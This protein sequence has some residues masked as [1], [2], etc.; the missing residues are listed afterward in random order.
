MANTSKRVFLK[1]SAAG[2]ALGLMPKTLQ[3]ET[4]KAPPPERDIAMGWE[5][6]EAGTGAWLAAT[7]PGT[8]HTDLFVNGK[9]PNPFYRTNER[10]LQWKPEVKERRA[11][12]IGV[13]CWVCGHLHVRREHGG[14]LPERRRGGP[15]GDGTGAGGRGRVAPAHR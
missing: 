5:F 7:V 3:A 12:N 14:R 11:S 15:G 1:A 13:E 8:V 4:R 6:R 2:A 9:I 10:D